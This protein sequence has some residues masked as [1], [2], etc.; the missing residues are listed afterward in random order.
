MISIVSSSRV[1]YKEESMK[2]LFAV[3]AFA[4]FAAGSLAQ[5]DQG[6]VH[7]LV[8]GAPW[9]Q[10]CGAQLPA[11]QSE[12]NKLADCKDQFEVVGY[13]CSGNST[14]Q[15]PTQEMADKYGSDL[16]LTFRMLPDE[17]QW[18]TFKKYFGW[19][20]RL[21]AAVVLD[22]AGQVLAKFLAEKFV[23]GDIKKIVEENTGESGHCAIRQ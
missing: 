1:N 14:A 7:V 19:D 16:G 12:L 2:P 4:M 18:K 20:Y 5:A 9:C 23:P 21:P 22:D 15:K 3:F 6:K 17:W 11:L 8:F 10:A 13:V